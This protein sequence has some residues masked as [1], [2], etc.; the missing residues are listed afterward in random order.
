MDLEIPTNPNLITKKNSPEEGKQ[1][2]RIRP[3]SFD[4]FIGQT[5][6]KENLLLFIQ[7][8]KKRQE[9]LD[10]C[11]LSGPPGLGKT[12]LANLIAKEKGTQ[13]FTL[14]GPALDKK[15]DIAS[16]LTDLLPGDILFIDEIHRIPIAIEEVLYSAMEDSH[17]DIIL[18]QGP[19]ARSVRIDL[20][21]FTLVGATTRSGL[22][23]SPL[24]DRFGIHFNLEFYNPKD[25]SKVVDQGARFLN[26][27][28]TPD[29]AR[30]LSTRSRGTPRVA[31]RLLRRARD[32][33]QIQNK[34]EIDLE[35]VC[36]A[37]QRLDVDHKGLDAMDRKILLTIIDLFDGGPVGLDTISASIGEEA[38]TV[39]EVYEPFLLQ[40]GLLQRTPRGRVAGPLA[41]QHLNR[42]PKAT[43]GTRFSTGGEKV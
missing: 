13:L 14:S 16:I 26:I 29:G 12:T 7:A 17:L 22:L 28:I 30:E 18:G 23:S 8:A 15:G 24:R 43:N 2:V 5:K 33:A 38:R 19:G 35:V 10:H 25:L 11:L 37:L 3:Q 39:G 21:P 42:K 4:Q 31:L 20:S 9:P 40:Q 34:R 36:E 27:S 32:F 6:V 41:Y 1:E